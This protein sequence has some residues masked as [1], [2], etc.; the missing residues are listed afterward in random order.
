MKSEDWMGATATD[1]RYRM[2][3][4]SIS[5]YA[6]YM[7]DREGRVTSWNP[8]AQRLKGYAEAEVLGQHFSRFYTDEARAAGEPALALGSAETRGR[9][10]SEGWS[11]RKDGT[12]FWADI[13]IDAIRSPSG[14]IIGFAKVTRDLSERKAAEQALRQS[15]DQF[16][17]IVENVT[18]YAI[19]MLDPT[20]LI[21]TW[22][23]GAERIKGYTREEILGR[24]FS[25]FYTLEDRAAGT[26]ARALEIAARTGKFEDESWRVRKDGT[27]F[28][29]SVV[30][31]AIR[32]ENG[33]LIGFAKITRD[34][35]ERRNTQRA[36]DEAKEALYQSQKM[37]AIGQLTGGVA[38]D[39]NNLLAAIISSLELVRKRE[40][41]PKTTALLNNALKA[42]NRGTLLIQRMLA[43]ARR[44][45][46]DI[47][48]VDVA[49]VVLGVCEIAQRTIGSSIEIETGIPNGLPAVAADE[50]QLEMALLNLIV[51]ARDAMN[52]NGTIRISA[53]ERADAA[54][55]NGEIKTSVC[56]SV[57]DDGAGM[58][59]ETLA[60]ATE[61]FFTTKG[62][63][64]GTGLGLSMVQGLVEQFGGVLRL[65][66][67]VGTGTVAEISLPAADFDTVPSVDA[68]PISAPV[69]RPRTILAVDDDGLVLMSVTAMLEDL[70]HT[71][72]T[73]SSGDRGIAI[74]RT[75]PAIDLVLTDQSMPG[76]TGAQFAEAAL[77]LRPGLPVILATGYAELPREA[78]GLPRLAKPYTQNDLE[79]ILATV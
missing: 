26:P 14:D 66:S 35:T 25:E 71:V 73:A 7:L 39:F 33:H 10:T 29:A 57:S 44:Q 72:V 4:D 18:D 22:N 30:I 43:F 27:Q 8:G 41:D 36:L 32:S 45:E 21:S 2:L 75:N 58:T 65:S 64:K 54:D 62:V 17:L 1:E 49:A 13:L 68:T 52:G 42:A 23:L 59:A 79:R 20:G 50:N 55:S 31:D 74:L 19:F 5:D 47:K 15:E 56:L 51:N 76:V 37:E 77:V 34:A 11:V 67:K 9:H 38:H 24:H 6:I 69:G 16:R 60:R 48:S 78:A 40:A 70:G 12:R 3:V 53:Y 28:W 63:G 61:P 46:L